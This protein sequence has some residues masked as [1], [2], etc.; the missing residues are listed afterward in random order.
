MVA[1]HV[2][3]VWWTLAYKPLRTRRHKSRRTLCQGRTVRACVYS[4]GMLCGYMPNSSWFICVASL[5]YYVFVLSPAPTWYII[6]LLWRDIAY[7]CWKCRQTPSKQTSAVWIQY[8]VHERGGQTEGRKPADSK[9]RANAWRRA[10]KTTFAHALLYPVMV[11][12]QSV[13]GWTNSAELEFG[14]VPN[15]TRQLVST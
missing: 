8:T 1:L 9:D 12:F 3:Q 13:Y 11:S 4:V 7:L 2:C 10:V 6:L 5:F 14:I 15:Q